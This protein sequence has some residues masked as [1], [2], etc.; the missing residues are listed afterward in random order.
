M[1][2]DIKKALNEVEHG[3]TLE[4]PSEAIT[5]EPLE[6]KIAILLGLLPREVNCAKIKEEIAAR[7]EKANN[8]TIMQDVKQR[9]FIG[10]HVELQHIAFPINNERLWENSYQNSPESS[11]SS[12]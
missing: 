1:L 10:D 5:G 7:L 11:R 8:R 12:K 4:V 2:L 6:D 3:T 9:I